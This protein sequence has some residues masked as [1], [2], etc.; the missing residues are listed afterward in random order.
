MTVLFN[1][2][3]T[4]TSKLFFDEF[5]TQKRA[6]LASEYMNYE[7]FYS[8]WH[9]AKIKYIESIDNVG[10]KIEISG[11]RHFKFDID[12]F[13]WLYNRFMRGVR[14]AKKRIHDAGISEFVNPPCVSETRFE[15][16]PYFIAKHSSGNIYVYRAS[17]NHTNG[18]IEIDI[19]GEPLCFDTVDSA[20]DYILQKINSKQ[21]PAIGELYQNLFVIYNKRTK[22]IANFSCSEK[23]TAVEWSDDALKQLKLLIES[24]LSATEIAKKLEIPQNTLVGKINSLGW[25]LNK[26]KG[27]PDKQDANLSS[28]T[29][30]IKPAVVSKEIDICHG[31]FSNKKA[32]EHAAK[33]LGKFKKQTDVWSVARLT[34]VE[35]DNCDKPYLPITLGYT[36]FKCFKQDLY[37]IKHLLIVGRTGT[38]KTTLLKSILASINRQPK[39]ANCKIILIDTKNFDFNGYSS[40]YLITPVITNP[41]KALE[42]LNQIQPNNEDIAIVID[43]LA[44]LIAVKSDIQNMLVNL[45]KNPKIHIIVATRKYDILTN[46]FLNLFH[47]TV[48]FNKTGFALYLSSDLFAK[49]REIRFKTIFNT[50]E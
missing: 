20:N 40:E 29:D 23:M 33:E 2:Y 46:N 24:G 43:E 11:V 26:T 7:E 45:A 32:A 41:E 16:I 14:S 17:G 3:N 4:Q 27:H 25:K 18:G 47:N 28:R 13:P 15:K 9:I 19:N 48:C 6:K 35:L 37:A 8:D 10:E 12:D 5:I 49:K 31:V 44:D 39:T 50:K 22:Q 36:G 1:I 30:Y 34:Q 21:Q 42:Y 38:G